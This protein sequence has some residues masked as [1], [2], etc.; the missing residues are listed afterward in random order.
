MKDAKVRTIAEND[1]HKYA[2][3]ACGYYEDL[4]LY[5]MRG[6]SDSAAILQIGHCW[7]SAAAA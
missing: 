1:T 6:G 4:V 5:T 3:V 7:Q 2:G